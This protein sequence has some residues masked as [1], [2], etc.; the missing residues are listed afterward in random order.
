MQ[1]EYAARILKLRL[2]E[3]NELKNAPERCSADPVKL[4]T[5]GRSIGE[6]VRIKRKDDSRFVA[7]YT[8][9][10]ANPTTTW[11]SEASQRRSRRTRRAGSGWA[12]MLTLQATVQAR[13]V[14]APPQPG[15]PDGA[16]FFEMADDDGK[17]PYFIAIAPHGGKS[18]DTPMNRRN[19]LSGN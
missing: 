14:D 8:V 9:K 7:L 12:P 15:E 10:Q 3:Q 18:N 1:T 19:R 13:V 17:Q 6:Q 2:P 5:I 11:R 16:R 4:E